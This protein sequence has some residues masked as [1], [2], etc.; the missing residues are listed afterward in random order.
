MKFGREDHEWDELTESTLQFLI[1]RAR[2]PSLTT[3][4]ELNAVLVRRTGLRGFDFDRPDERAA[5]GELLARV[6]ER[7]H[8]QTGLMISAL[9]RYLDANDAGTGFYKFAQDLGLL[10]RGASADEKEAFWVGQVA[11]LYEYYA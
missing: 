2:L 4:T 7:N 8:P 11:S 5:M 3:Y 9:V 1:E 6:V 10:R